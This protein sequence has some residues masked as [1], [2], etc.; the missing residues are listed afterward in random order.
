[1]RDI[2]EPVATPD[3]DGTR[4]THPAFGQITVHRT[5][6]GRGVL[7]GSDFVHHSYVTIRIYESE[8]S[9][10]LSRDWHFAK[11]EFVEVALSEAQWATFVSSFNI[12]AGVPCTIQ[13]R[14]GKMIPGFPLRDEGQEY[15]VEAN[16]KLKECLDLID[17]TLVEVR[18]EASGLSKAKRERLTGSLEKARRELGANLPFVAESFGEHMEQRVEKARVE[19]HAYLAETVRRAGLDQIE[20]MK[21]PP[22]AMIEADRP[23][24]KQD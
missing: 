11:R 8:L 10:G 18:D 2:Q 6:G 23:E 16:A 1:M 4:Y 13:H 20:A 19:I 14:D 9:R 15:R 5:H 21:T 24:Q 22:I 17:A 7:Y 12:G 3:R